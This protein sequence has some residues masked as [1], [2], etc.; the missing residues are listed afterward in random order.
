MH[1]V[2]GRGVDEEPPVVGTCGSFIT[3][4]SFG[5]VYRITVMGRGSDSD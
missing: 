2:S 4:D 3:E 1:A 5:N